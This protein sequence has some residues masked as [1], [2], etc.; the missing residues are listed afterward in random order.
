MTSDLRA[1]AERAAKDRPKPHWCAPDYDCESCRT[2]ADAIERVARQAVEAEREAC[3]QELWTKVRVRPSHIPII[4]KC[5]EALIAR[6][7]QYE[8]RKAK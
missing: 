1:L 5:M 6:G 7:A 3:V 2:V 8:E 4:R